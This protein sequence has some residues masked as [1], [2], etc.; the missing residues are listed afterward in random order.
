MPRVR[1]APVAARQRKLVVAALVRDGGRI[2][3]TQR[4]AD[5]SMPLQ[6]EFPGGKIEEGESPTAALER[7]LAEELGARSRVGPIYEVLFYRYRDFDLYLLVYECVLEDAPRPVEVAQ[8]EWVTP[9]DLGRYSILPADAPV[10][11]RLQRE[12]AR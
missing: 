10:V 7:E 12:A 2:L 6:W 9:E 4:R 3:L 5:Q 11:A 8:V 1:C